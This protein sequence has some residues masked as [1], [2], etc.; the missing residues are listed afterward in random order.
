MSFEF[1]EKLLEKVKDFSII[2]LFLK[3][4]YI[5]TSSK[6]YEFSYSYNSYNSQFGNTSKKYDLQKIMKLFDEKI[7]KL[8]NEKMLDKLLYTDFFS[9]F[10]ISKKTNEITSASTEIL[11]KEYLQNIRLN[12][13]IFT[14]N[15]LENLADLITS[16]EILSEVQKNFFPITILI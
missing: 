1:L 9:E 15:I 7:K 4:F 13:N 12:I 5:H 16:K 11:T 10:L 3:D 14:V 8:E 2:S 6:S